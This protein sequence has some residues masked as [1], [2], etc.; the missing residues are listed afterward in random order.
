MRFLTISMICLGS[1][2][3]YGAF[4]SPQPAFECKGAGENYEFIY[5]I[6]DERYAL[7]GYPESEDEY[8]NLETASGE[9]ALFI[10]KKVR[11]FEASQ[12]SGLNSN[13]QIIA[14]DESVECKSTKV[15]SNIDGAGDKGWVG[16][17]ALETIVR[18]GPSVDAKRI[19]K[20]PL[21][22]PVAILRNEGQSYQN[23]PW[24][25]IEYSEGLRGYA[26]GGTLCS[27]GQMIEGVAAT[28]A[29]VQ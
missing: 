29:D 26:W 23:H 9:G 2:F 24:F 6:D 13:I 1:V 4:A 17:M 10:G 16:G 3:S 21:K 18:E 25:L 19:D 14:T 5:A 28:C 11:F 12:E 20:L 27:E 8:L 22:E 15:A 7:T